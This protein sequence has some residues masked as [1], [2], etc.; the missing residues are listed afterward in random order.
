MDK[1]PGANSRADS[2][3]NSTKVAVMAPVAKMSTGESISALVGRWVLAWFFLVMTYRYGYDWTDTAILLSMKGVPAAQLLLL[4]GLATNVLGSVS[5]L[6]G[7]HTRVGAL[8]LFVVTVASTVAVYDYWNI[9]APLAREADFDIFARNIAVAGGLLLL[10][11][12][13]PGK[14]A[15]D[16]VASGGR[17]EARA[18]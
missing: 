11:G 4:A 10:I 13:G 3:A 15:L 9:G 5:L 14:F 2:G 16:N 8:G 6:I 7:F 17:V 12:M 18:H 1:A